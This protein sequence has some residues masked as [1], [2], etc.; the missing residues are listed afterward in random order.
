MLTKKDR[1]DIRKIFQEELKSA[2]TIEMK[3]EKHRD[4]NTGQPLAV[5]VVETIKVWLPEEW[6]RHIPYFEGAL[7]GMQETTDRAKNNS[8]KAFQGMGAVAEIL[9]AIE[10]PLKHI[11]LTATDAASFASVVND[12]PEIVT[13]MIDDSESP[14]QSPSE[15]D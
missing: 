4:E 11:A 1:D 13:K 15:S 5:P 6:A 3:M 2:F 12:N 10:K 9:Q 14:S 7:R 8:I